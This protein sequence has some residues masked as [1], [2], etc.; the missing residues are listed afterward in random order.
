MSATLTNCPAVTAT[1]LS[2]SVPAVGSV[3]IFTANS[4]LAG[5]SFGSLKPKSRRGKRVTG[6]L[7]ER[8]DRAARAWGRID[9]A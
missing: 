1:P 7:L 2:V 3:V 4:V 8:R 5:L 6:R 9:C